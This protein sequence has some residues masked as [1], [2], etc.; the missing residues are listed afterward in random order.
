MTWNNIVCWS[1]LMGE[2]STKKIG[3]AA[4]AS[5][6]TWNIF[7]RFINSFT[8]YSDKLVGIFLAQEITLEAQIEPSVVI[9]CKD[10]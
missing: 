5:N 9:I 10:I 3:T 8:I 4:I 6:T 7:L 1:T 2:V